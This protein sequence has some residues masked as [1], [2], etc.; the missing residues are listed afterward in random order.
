MSKPVLFIPGY[1]GSHLRVRGG[2]RIFLKLGAFLPTPAESVMRRLEGP[3]DLAIDDGIEAGP[4]IA[5]LAKI[6][7]F[8]VGKQAKTLYKILDKLDVDPVVK[9]GWD[10]RRPVWD[11]GMQARLETEIRALRRRSGQRVVA[12]VHS[13]GGLVLRCL[14]ESKP[15]MAAL[16]ER[17]IAFGVPWAG[18]LKSLRFLDGQ[19]KFATLRELRAQKLIANSWAAFDL[20]PPDPS[21]TAL[22]DANGRELKLVIDG[23]GR[24]VGPQTKTDWFPPDLAGKMRPRAEKAH[25]KLGRRSASLELGGRPLNV[26]NIIGWGAK[27]WVQA[28]IVGS[29]NQQ[30]ITDWREVDD[31]PDLDGGD[32]T[33]P[34]R[35]ASWLRGDGVSQYH[36]P[37]GFHRGAQRFPHSSLWRNPGGRNL[38]RHLLRGYALT[39]FVYAAVDTSDFKNRSARSVR[40]RLSTLNAGGQPLSG[41]KVRAIDLTQGR[42]IEKEYDPPGD[43]RHLLLVPRRRMQ[44]VHGNRFRRFTL[45]ID[46]DSGSIRRVLVVRGTRG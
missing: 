5:R 1:P 43:G 27:T 17:V 42:T 21:T 4:P 24:Q 20:L 45:Q 16:F 41:V 44:L 11:V 33:V 3:D 23:R 35:S 6:L 34:F 10:W 2:K 46:W 36:V 29:G 30:R 38:L 13:T 31:S 9:F 37:V 25:E 12:V 32:G 28:A 40:V 22:V 39:P 14:L 26:T 19:D 15:A 7:L 8:E 18:L